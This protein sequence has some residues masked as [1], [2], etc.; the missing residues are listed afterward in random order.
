MTPAVLLTATT[1]V[2]LTIGGVF[3][4]RALVRL[5]PL[6]SRFP[7]LGFAAWFAATG[8]W[9]ALF[10]ALGPV[11]A[12]FGSRQILPGAAGEVCQRC[13]AATN[14]FGQASGPV[15]NTLPA[16]VFVAIPAL[17]VVGLALRGAL[18]ALRARRTLRR[19]GRTLDMV[20][21]LHAERVWVLPDT[22]LGAYSIPLGRGRVVLTQGTVDALSASE[23]TAVIAHER[24]HLR[25]Q[26]HAL[27]AWVRLLS[28]AFGWV[29][30][31]RAAAPIVGG[32]A[33][34]AADD[35]AARS[36]SNP[37]TVARALAKLQ[38]LA[39][40]GL[41]HARELAGGAVAAVPALHAAQSGVPARVRRLLQPDDA[42]PL[43]V[44]RCLLTAV[45]GY[46]LGAVALV[47]TITSPY[48]SVVVLGAC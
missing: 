35:A 11:L 36:V 14:P 18:T 40:D 37:A 48:V 7:R 9:A 6:F 10:L 23:L 22:Q 25:Q 16:A 28:Q 39:H 32:Y 30:L 38:V 45:G 5:T 46:V 47:L 1:V 8:V 19:H 21:T 42:G 27:L 20:S 26:H 43:P 17:I 33:E 41:N 4:H 44:P 15:A 24:A 3:G 13:L 31:L 12:W 29:P 2:L 34:L